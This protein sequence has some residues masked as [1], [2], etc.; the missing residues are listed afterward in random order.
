MSRP[1]SDRRFSSS[2]NW[3]NLGC[4]LTAWLVI[5]GFAYLIVRALAS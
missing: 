1:V 2:I 3:P 4:G 5:G